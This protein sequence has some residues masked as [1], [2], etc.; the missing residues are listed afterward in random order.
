MNQ[1][2]LEKLVMDKAF[3]TLSR[4]VE[5]LLDAYLAKSPA[6]ARLARET[7]EAI[8]MART[9]MKPSLT[10]ALPRL[11]TAPL[12]LPKPRREQ[13][14]RWAAAWPLKLAAVFVFG[15]SMGSYLV[16]HAEVHTPPTRLVALVQNQHAV[17][18]S[19]IWSVQRWTNQRAENPPAQSSHI[20]WKS[21][22][23][24]PQF[25]N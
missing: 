5:A 4:D 7:S 6:D 13:D 19:S 15:L 1:E 16:R 14:P 11:K 3:G 18:A 23:E 12:S 9:L 2:I 24:K 25:N 21:P 22:L 17:D 20:V 10:S 8:A